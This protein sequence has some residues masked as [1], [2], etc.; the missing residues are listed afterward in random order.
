[1]GTAF[2]LLLAVGI[3]IAVLVYTGVFQT[4]WA[5]AVNIRW[6]FSLG[7]IGLAAG[8]FSIVAIACAWQN[9]LALFGWTLKQLSVMFFVVMVSYERL[10]E[11][12]AALFDNPS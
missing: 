7:A 6:R 9:W 2:V 8:A 12:N 1:M 5:G 4:A 3:A 10:G 11:A